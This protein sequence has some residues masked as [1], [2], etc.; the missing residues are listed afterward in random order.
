MR[1]ARKVET[2]FNE[3]SHCINQ[4]G[5]RSVKFLGM[6]VFFLLLASAAQ[7]ED[8]APSSSWT[9]SL[10]ATHAGV[11]SQGGQPSVV[12]G[13]SRSL[14]EGYISLS[15]TLTDSSDHSV[16]PGTVPERTEFISISGGRAFGKIM[17]EVHAMTG[18][19][20]YRQGS[21]STASGE[22]ITI[23]SSLTGYGMG[24]S[25]SINVSLGSN[26]DFTPKVGLDYSSV[27]TV[28]TPVGAVT[29]DDVELKSNGLTASF[30]GAFQTRF[31][32][33]QQHGLA[34]IGSILRVE[35]TSDFLHRNGRVN[36]SDIQATNG[37]TILD[38]GGTFSIGINPDT[39]LDLSLTRSAGTKGPESTLLGVTLHTAF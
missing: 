28:R 7:A 34:V 29:S 10:G 33:E 20:A 4:Q 24:V 2:K 25:A 22:T 8:V 13:V 37:D 11:D 5:D 17:V 27:K 35:N 18:R 12:V 1:P 38:Y 21:L 3:N 23:D 39:G 30:G 32:A 15:G 9:L 16:P 36:I 31:G 26:L 6:F 19:G 14:G